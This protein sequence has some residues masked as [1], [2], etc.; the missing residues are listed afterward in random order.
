MFY[1]SLLE[2]FIIL[3]VGITMLTLSDIIINAARDM[4]RK[5]D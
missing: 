2:C 5:E 3:C 1:F 4:L